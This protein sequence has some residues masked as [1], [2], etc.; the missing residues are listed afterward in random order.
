MSVP[1]RHPRVLARLVV[2]CLAAL[3]VAS[4]G[5]PKP[6]TGPGTVD[7]TDGV[8]KGLAAPLPPIDPE[9]LRGFRVLIDPGHGGSFRGTMGRDSLQ[10]AHVN[11][12][13]SLYL[14]GLLREAGADVH[15]TRAI[16]RDFLTRADST[17]TYDLQTRVDMVD[18]LNPD[19]FLSVH[20][21]AQP[22]RDPGMN[23][24]ETYYKAGDPA[25]LDLAFAIHRHLMRNL[26]IDVGEVRQ[27]NYYVLRNVGVPAVLGESS[28]LTHPPVE[29]KLKLSRAQQLEA[30][31]YFLGIADYC[32]RGVPRVNVV[33]PVDSVLSDVPL[34]LTRLE[35]HGGAGIDPDGVSFTVNG[36]PVT[37]AV[38]DDGRN[39]RWQAPWDA[40][41]GP[42]EVQIAA[43]NLGGNTGTPAI[44]RFTVNHPAAMAAIACDPERAPRGGSLR[45]HARILDRRGLAVADGT[46]VTLTSPLLR[47][48]GTGL[49]H[50]GAVEFALDVPANA[51]R[52]VKF[53]VACGS[54]RVAREVALAGESSKRRSLF[55]RD[56][57]TRAPV[58][59]A[60]VASGDS[61]TGT[62]SPS[63]SYTAT[64]A[65]MVAA[66]GYMPAS[67]ASGD[68]LSLTPWFA[69]VLHG[70]RFV[71]DPEGG[72]PRVAGVGPMGL[73]AS[74]VNLRVAQYL[75]GYLRAAGAEVRLTRNSEEVR[76]VE[77]VAR[78]TN[79]FRAD[80][81]LELRH[82]S[83]PNDSALAVRAYYFPGS[84]N[85]LKMATTMGNEIARRLGVAHRG[86]SSLVTYPLQQTACP[87]IVVALPQISRAEEEAKLDRAWYQRE[88]AYAVFV[89][90][91]R[92]Y[93][94]T[95]AGALTV[96]VAAPER[97]DW[98]V[99]IDGTWTLTTGENGSVRFEALAPGAHTVSLRRGDTRVT[100]AATV[101]DAASSLRIDPTLP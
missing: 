89:S 52:P 30:E 69:G 17:L 7:K 21:N 73:S 101:T 78:M 20:H 12:G 31:A 84:A 55:V 79:R 71:L 88:Q 83:L 13:V 95:D 28:Y 43:R 32:A 92:H 24:V 57:L 25:S 47:T 4:C 49:V 45:V 1:H 72:T 26:G 38:S 74:H 97:A 40:P 68:T 46:P 23:R 22:E 67:S 33:L 8:Y 99:T 29:E 94:V 37:V 53:E 27:G 15:L 81:Y 42:Y 63:G 11:L 51:T 96:E 85:G 14:W 59:M 9:L 100:R 82:P 58:L 76:L 91:L 70:K 34:V 3:A 90:L 86:P 16:D 50:D 60:S 35:D 6:G 54:L 2:V 5:G 98:V 65:V 39:A 66:P 61:V 18:S 44:K 75:A 80:R 62:G 93:A 41:N 87:A 64:G 77:D 56:E 10:E 19:I 36:E 48:P